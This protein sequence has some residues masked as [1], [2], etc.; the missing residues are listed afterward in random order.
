MLSLYVV[1]DEG[2]WSDYPLFPKVFKQAGYDVTFLTNQF[3]TKAKEAVFDFSGGFFLNHPQLSDAM[4]SYR[5]TTIHPWDDG[6]LRDWDEKVSSGEVGNGSLVIFHL[7][8]GKDKDFVREQILDRY[9]P[10]WSNKKY[11]DFQN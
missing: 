8:N 1:G 5:N 6:L 11:A 2:S 4:F 3:L 10:D 7:K 9:Y